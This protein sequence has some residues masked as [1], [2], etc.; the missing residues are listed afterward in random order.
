MI[1]RIVA[2][3]EWLIAYWPDLV[4][5]RLPGTARPWRQPQL[6]P[7][8]R[9][10]LDAQA[11]IERAERSD[12]ALGESP[13]PV[14]VA[15]LDVMAGVL[16]DAADIAEQATGAAGVE[17]LEPPST[18]Y[19]DAR[20]YLECAV[21]MLPAVPWVADE[22]AATARLMVGAVA[23]ALCLV[24]DGQ[25]LDVVCPWCGGRTE[26]AP[27]GGAR[28]WRVRQLPGDLVAIVCGGLCEPPSKDVGTWWRGRPCWPVAEWDWLAKRVTAAERHERLVS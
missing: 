27:A 24:Y 6:T 20:P 23:H 17:R 25:S 8:R 21:K 19:A 28:T 7:E 2:D 10:E 4:V 14:D 13:A 22:V 26:V 18:A 11:R 16:W 3:L 12:V 9:A 1:N 15:I 5:A